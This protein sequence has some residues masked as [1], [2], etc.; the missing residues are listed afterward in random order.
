MLNT[1]FKPLK[2]TMIVDEI[3]LQIENT[4]SPCNEHVFDPERKG[5][6]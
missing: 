1:S 6:P 4:G 2:I 5:Q 3:R